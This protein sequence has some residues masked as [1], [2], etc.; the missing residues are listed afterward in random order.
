M[1]GNKHPNDC[2]TQTQGSWSSL[3]FPPFWTSGVTL[4]EVF[5]VDNTDFVHVDM[6]AMETILEAHYWLQ[7]SVINWGHLLIA[8]GG[9]LKPSK[10]SFYL[11]SFKWKADGTWVYKDNVIRSDLAIAIPLADG[12]L[13]EI[14]HL[15]V[16]NAVKTLGSMMCPTRS[17]TAALGRMQQQGQEWVDRVKSGKLSGCNVWFMVDQQFWPRVE[18]GICNILATWDNLDQCPR[19]I[20]WQLVPRGGVR[21]SAV[22]PLRQLDRGFYGIGCPHPGVKCLV[23][24]IT[25]LMVHYGYQF[26]MQVSMELLLTEL[27]ISAQPL[28]E[29]FVRYGKW[30]TGTWLKSIWEKVDKFRIT[31]EIAPLPVCPPREGDKWFI[32]A[33]MEAGVTDPNQQ[34][35]LNQFRCH[36][37]VLYV[38]NVLDA[39][40]KCLDKKY[41][42]RQK[43]YKLWLTLVF[44]QEKPPIKHLHL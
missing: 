3:Y 34:R 27:G 11:I 37:Q 19:R 17:S 29:S 42:D 26:E 36:Q 16:S 20:Y 21:G 12:S 32:R 35:I 7:E 18:Y 22:A 40:E 9:A 31:V 23:A 8:S 28:Q 2:R 39:V 10:C 4:W 6:Q 5:F 24:Q 1:D 41:L 25:K 33:A 30:I 14:E 44:P 43:P 38:S 15:P 13:A